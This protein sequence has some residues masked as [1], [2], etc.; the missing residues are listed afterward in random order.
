MPKYVY[1]LIPETVHEDWASNTDL[2]FPAT[3]EQL[4]TI[5]LTVDADNE[6]ESRAARMPVSN[7]MAWELVETIEE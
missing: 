3:D 5:T 6:E 1:K 7:I 4:A 2:P